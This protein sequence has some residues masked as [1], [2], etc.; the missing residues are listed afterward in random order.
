MISTYC[1]LT[2][3]N[4]VKS[5]NTSFNLRDAFLKCVTP[6]ESILTEE[7]MTREYRF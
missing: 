7:E 4:L 6:A 1:F 3:I 5:S 2:S